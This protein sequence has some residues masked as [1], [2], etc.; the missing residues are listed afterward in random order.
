MG[1]FGFDFN[2]D[3]H[4]SFDE[5]MI[6][7]DIMGVFDDEKKDDCFLDDDD[8]FDL[9]YIDSQER[10]EELENN[11]SALE[12][13]LFNLEL[14]EPD[15]LSPAYDSWSAHRDA[16]QDQIDQM[17]SDISDLED[18]LSDSESW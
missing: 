10:L 16:L 6:S 7:L 15:I 13:A 5:H 12:D 8:D 14:H 18:S 11:R 17:D 9:D 2:G 4:V 3:G 1:W